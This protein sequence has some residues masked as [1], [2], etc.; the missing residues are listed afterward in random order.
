MKKLKMVTIFL[1][2]DLSVSICYP[3]AYYIATN[4]Y[5]DFVYIWTIIASHKFGPPN[6][7]WVWTVNTNFS[8]NITVKG[9]GSVTEEFWYWNIAFLFTEIFFFAFSQ[10]SLC[11]IKM[12]NTFQFN[13]FTKHRTLSV[14]SS[15]NWKFG[16]IWTY[17]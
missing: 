8:L 11:K 9:K 13:Y 6:N 17:F 5:P 15:Q 7:F 12:Q 2:W 14:K 3:L 4:A 10:N 16:R 1:I